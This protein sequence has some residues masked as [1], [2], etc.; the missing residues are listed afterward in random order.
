MRSGWFTACALSAACVWAALPGAAPAPAAPAPPAPLGGLRSAQAYW[1]A[2]RMASAVPVDAARSR[3]AATAHAPSGTA[4]GIHFDGMPMVGTFFY[5]QTG[6]GTADTSCTGSVVRSRGKSMVLTAGHCAAGMGRPENRAV[7]VPRYRH[8]KTAAAQPFGIFP[9]KAEGGVYTDPRYRSHSRAAVSDLDLAFVLVEPNGRGRIEKVT[10]A[11]TFTPVSTYEHEVTVVGYPSASRVNKDHKPVRCDVPTTRLSGFRQLRM[12]CKGFYGGVSGGP[13]IKDYD[14]ARRTGKV[15]GNTGGYHGGGNDSWVTYA[16]LYGKDARDLYEDADTG[17]DPAALSRPP[18]RG[19]GDG[20]PLPGSGELWTHAR[21]MASGDFTGSGRSSLL[22]VWTDGEVTLFPGDGRGGFLP[23]RRL[24]APNAGWKAV[25]TITAGDFTGS[26]QFD[27][28]VRRKD[29][30]MTL[31]ADV[32]SHGLGRVTEMAPSG[33]VWRHATQIAAGRFNA[34][35]YVTDLVVRWSDG[36]LTLHTAVGA[37]TFGREHRLKGPGP[38]WKGA[39]LLAAGQFS[40]NRKW[41]LM[42]RWSNG[43]LVSHTGITTRGL[44]GAR[45]VRGPNRTWPH[46]ALMTAGRYTGDGLTDDL[47]V[48]WSD[49]ETSLYEDTRTNGLGTERMLVPPRAS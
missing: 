49:G 17:R 26:D 47:V 29:G 15:I 30:R 3:A 5:R 4:T 2:D 9:V 20:L 44:G 21:A 10:G 40:G 35:T 42:V 31:H 37:G 34:S 13:W 14:P 1:T 24:M 7:F 46:S 27:L 43:A 16:P 6:I 32:G 39:A 12:V 38:A 11:L 25:A 28:M 8:G 22:V 18:Y 33:S 41:D 19:S 23:E 48:R 45:P 36:E